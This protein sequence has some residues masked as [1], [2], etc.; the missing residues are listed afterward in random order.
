MYCSPKVGCLHAHRRDEAVPAIC[1][2]L[3]VWLCCRCRRRR[4]RERG[5]L[6]EGDMA[7]PNPPR[8]PRA[9]SSGR[10]FGQSTRWAARA[11]GSNA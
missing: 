11:M 9:P 3:A 7:L 8:K 2:C 10:Q 1:R 6:N 5:H 4:R